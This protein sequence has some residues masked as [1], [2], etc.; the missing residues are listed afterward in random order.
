M[1]GDDIKLRANQKKSKIFDSPDQTKSFN[2]RLG[3][4]PLCWGEGSAG[5]RNDFILMTLTFFLSELIL[6]LVQMG[7]H[8]L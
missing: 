5:I 1:I 7:T 2:V 4:S 6:H 8:Q 3:V